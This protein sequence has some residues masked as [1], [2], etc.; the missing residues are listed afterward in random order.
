MRAKVEEVEREI[1][2]LTTEIGTAQQEADRL[3]S[4]GKW[5]DAEQ[6]IEKALSD[7]AKIGLQKISD[8]GI[9]LYT[10]KSEYRTAIDLAKNIEK[11]EDI[12]KL[13]DLKKQIKAELTGHEK[14]EFLVLKRRYEL[15]EK[16]L[17][18][19]LTNLQNPSIWERASNFRKSQKEKDT[20]IEVLKKLREIAREEREG[21][22]EEESEDQRK[23]REEEIRRRIINETA[24]ILSNA[25]TDAAKIGKEAEKIAVERVA[26]A[27]IIHEM[28]EDAI[29]K[30]KRKMK[31]Q[32]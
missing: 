4:E 10:K 5:S 27:R 2:D 12:R 21:L 13:D 17:E 6:E 1:S 14:L 32:I 29:H 28:K 19:R 15:K 24:G 26:L 20:E 23:E 7:F 31:K 18:E 25:K 8:V 30:V 22:K 3:A 16:G 11:E 9:E